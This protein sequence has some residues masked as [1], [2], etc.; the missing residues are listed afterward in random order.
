MTSA[1]LYKSSRDTKKYM[2]K[3]VFPDGKKRTVH[4]G[5]RGA[6]DYTITGDKEQ[7]QRYIDRHDNKR[8][9]WTVPDTPASLSRWVLWGDTTS[10]QKNFELFKKKFKLD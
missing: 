10:I 7:R 2:V 8:E 6:D 9:D 4:F 3:F 1:K 5:Q